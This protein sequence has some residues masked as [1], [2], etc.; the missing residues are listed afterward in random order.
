MGRTLGDAEMKEVMFIILGFLFGILWAVAFATSAE[1]R[2][3]Y[4]DRLCHSGTPK[5]CEINREYNPEG[6]DHEQH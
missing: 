1:F 3:M 6:E 2:V 5:A 4:L